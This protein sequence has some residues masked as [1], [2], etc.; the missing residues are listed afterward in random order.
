VFVTKDADLVKTARRMFTIKQLTTGQMCGASARINIRG[1]RQLMAVTPDY[2][3]CE[4]EV[5]D[6]FIQVCTAT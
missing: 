4:K 6:K 1:T 3:L 5:V 2:I